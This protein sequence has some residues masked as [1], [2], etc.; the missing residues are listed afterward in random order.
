P[1]GIGPAGG[2]VNGPAGSSIVVPANALAANTAIAIAQSS[3]GAPALPAELE[4][5]GDM[6]AI[7]PHGTAFAVAATVTVPFDPADVPPGRTVQL[8]KTNAAQNGWESVASTTSGN[9]LSAQTSSLSWW[10][11]ALVAIGP[12]ITT[13]PADV[14]VDVG[15]SA[16]FE[17]VAEANGAVL[18][19]QWKR[20]D[21]DIPGATG[22]SYTLPGTTIDDDGDRFSVLVSNAIGSV[23]SREALLTVESDV[24]TGWTQ[25]GGDVKPVADTSRALV[26]YPSV[27]VHTDGTIYVAYAVHSSVTPSLQGFLRVSTW[28]PVAETWN[29]VGGDLNI[30]AFT[31]WAPAWPAIRVASDG[32]PVVAWLN[33]WLVAGNPNFVNEIVVQRW[34]GS[35][36]ARIGGAPSGVSGGALRAS[37]PVLA[38]D[39]AD[40]PHVAFSEG[41][42][43]V[44]RMW[45]GSAWAPDAQRACAA[46]N[47]SGLAFALNGNDTALVAG[48]PPPPP[49][50]VDP[51][52]V[53]D[54]QAQPPVICA[55]TELR[56]WI[57]VRFRGTQDGGFFSS[58]LGGRPVNTTRADTIGTAGL[59]VDEFNQP[60]LAFVS[61]DF[62]NPNNVTLTAWRNM[63]NVW[64]A[65]GGDLFGADALFS[66][67]PYLSVEHVSG[68]PLVAWL[69]GTPASAGPP[70]MPEVGRIAGRT[71]DGLAWQD[72]PTP[73]DAATNIGHFGFGVSPQDGTLHVAFTERLAPTIQNPNPDSS[74]GMALYV[75]RCDAGCN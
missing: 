41:T 68:K 52:C 59:A 27:A 32:T 29:P 70:A 31:D 10:L 14:T 6:F 69:S 24:P 63:N 49:P 1:A 42:C 11:A 60:V 21:V 16:T 39:T 67:M 73:H 58:Q 5:A 19:F 43:N 23:L 75:R 17:V 50:Q 7:T 57:S 65:L 40:Q 54:P 55:L 53:Q 35:T 22:A 3:A 12:T 20:N 9:N 71:W 44:Y 36:W 62:S 46:S 64:N 30:G 13:E 33:R 61:S 56:N 47:Q 37:A 74:R 18:G 34:D 25:I 66:V 4:P 15:Q 51:N 28:D 48:S 2:T 38:L 8:M 45:D 72:L 26:R